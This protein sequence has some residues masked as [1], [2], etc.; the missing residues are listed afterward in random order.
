MGRFW[1]RRLSGKSI[2]RL[3]LKSWR[4]GK[5]R[6]LEKLEVWSG[7]TITLQ[8]LT[9]DFHRTGFYTK[10][11]CYEI[12][13][14]LFKLM[15]KIIGSGTCLSIRGFGTWKIRHIPMWATPYVSIYMRKYKRVAFYP[16]K[17]LVF[18]MNPNRKATIND[19]KLFVKNWNPEYWSQPYGWQKANAHE[20]V[21]KLQYPIWMQSKLV[22]EKRRRERLGLDP[23]EVTMETIQQMNSDEYIQKI[24]D[25]LI[26]KEKARKKSK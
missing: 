16:A 3:N 13:Y 21:K 15:T 9:D 1:R 23:N 6:R 24:I 7:N 17:R 10:R 5:E 26:A 20:C 14:G 8:D 12:M 11:E 25:S 22:R 2:Y 4:I 18:R 19:Y